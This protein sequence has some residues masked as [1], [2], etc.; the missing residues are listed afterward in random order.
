MGNSIQTNRLHLKVMK[1]A[2]GND[3][4]FAGAAILASEMSNVLPD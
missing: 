1:A 2:L 4:G 3:A